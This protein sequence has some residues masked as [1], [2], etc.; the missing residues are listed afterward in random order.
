[1]S[2]PEPS[3]NQRQIDISDSECKTCRTK[4]ELLDELSFY[5]YISDEMETDLNKARQEIDS[6][7]QL[8]GRLLEYRTFA[9]ENNEMF[10]RW[11]IEKASAFMKEKRRQRKMEEE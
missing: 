3:R 9:M 10:D 7:N 1:M 2:Q 8:V 6:L 5:Q 4:E 11:R